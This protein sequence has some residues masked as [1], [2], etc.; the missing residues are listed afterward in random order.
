MNMP[1]L[2]FEIQGIYPL[3]KEAIPK[4]KILQGRKIDE[5]V[6]ESSIGNSY[7]APRTCSNWSFHQKS[8]RTE[9]SQ[10]TI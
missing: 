5:L 1:L 3:N 4:E 10:S 6:A 9:P 2:L 8:L 7:K